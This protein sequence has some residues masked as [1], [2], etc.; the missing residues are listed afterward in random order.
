MG[1]FGLHVAF[2]D[3]VP[4]NGSCINKGGYF[5]DVANA[6]ED[7]DGPMAGELRKQAG[8]A[9]RSGLNHGVSAVYEASST[10]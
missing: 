8:V 7:W 1:L 10:T 6:G 9:Q 3:L 2:R 4:V 5:V